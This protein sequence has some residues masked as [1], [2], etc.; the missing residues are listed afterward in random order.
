MPPDVSDAAAAVYP[1]PTYA[2]HALRTLAAAESTLLSPN[3]KRD[4]RR[5]I[6]QFLLASERHAGQIVY[7]QHRPFRVDVDPAA[8]YR[9]DC[10][11]YVTQAF[12]WAQDRLDGPHLHDP[13]GP[14]EYDGWGWTGTLYTTNR[15]HRV[16]LDHRM[17]VGDLA[18]YGR[19]TTDT[20]H[21]T[22]CRRN[23]WAADAVFSSHGS[24]AGPLPT[25]L[26]YRPDLLG[27]YRPQSLL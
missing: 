17:F 5:L 20:R 25:K 10:S 16:P 2:E 26:G 23:G 22:V 19:S 1:T 9:G 11:S 8:G 3:E 7:S 12:A 18:L 4:A 14:V 27:V 24:Q 13:N 6:A 15:R 21:V